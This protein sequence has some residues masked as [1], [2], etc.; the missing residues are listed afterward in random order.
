MLYEVITAAD[1]LVVDVREV[2]HKADLITAVFQIAAHGVEYDKRARVPDMEKII[3]RWSAGVHGYLPG[4]EWN[5]FFLSARHRI[6]DLHGVSSVYQSL[7][8]R[9]NFV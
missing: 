4:Y 5:E 2:L 9:N 8:H 1:H 6:I 3:N 7:Y